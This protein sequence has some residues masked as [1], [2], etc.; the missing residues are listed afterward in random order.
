MSSYEDL[1]ATVE[2]IIDAAIETHMHNDGLGGDVNQ[3]FWDGLADSP[4]YRISPPGNPRSEGGEITDEFGDKL[5]MGGWDPGKDVYERYE[6]AIRE[7]F[8]NW[9]QLPDPGSFRGPIDALVDASW[10]IAVTAEAELILDIGNPALSSLEF[11]KDKIVQVES[12]IIST[13]AELYAYELPMVMQGQYELVAL[14]TLLLIGEKQ[15]WTHARKDITEIADLALDAMKKASPSMEFDEAAVIKTVGSLL[16]VAGAFPSPAKPILDGAGTVLTFFGSL[17]SNPEEPT[18]PEVDLQAGSPDGCVTKINDAIGRLNVAISDE[19]LAI[20][21][22]VKQAMDILSERPWAF[23]IDRPELVDKSVG[24]IA[25]EIKHDDDIVKHICRT[26]MPRIAGFLET[27]AGLIPG[28]K[29]STDWWRPG[30]IGLSTYGPYID[31]AEMMTEAELRMADT[32]WELLQAATHLQDAVGDVT[33]A[34]EQAESDLRGTVKGLKDDLGWT[35]TSLTYGSE[36]AGLPP[37]AP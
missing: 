4:R 35:P 22:N 16:T 20:S 13:F 37:W 10:E 5:D 25:G 33:E 28:T 27:A 12:T 17:M 1:N 8:A 15:I 7:A 29:H 24:K 9:D 6:S 32:A 11:L 26:T 30:T 21:D 3:G 2:D 14:G 19:E 23:D 34:D 31:W 18:K 36:T